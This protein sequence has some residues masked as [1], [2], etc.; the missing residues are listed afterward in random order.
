MK[1]IFIVADDLGTCNHA[2]FQVAS[3]LLLTSIWNQIEL[4]IPV[5]FVECHLETIIRILIDVY[6][7]LKDQ[8]VESISSGL[9]DL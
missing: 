1:E 8:A 7:Y 3:Q 5:C 6:L 9:G 2:F 4:C